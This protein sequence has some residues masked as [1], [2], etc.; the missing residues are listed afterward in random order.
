M[1]NFIFCAVLVFS[2]PWKKWFNGLPIFFIDSGVFF[3]ISCFLCFEA[4]RLNYLFIITELVI[5][6]CSAKKLFLKILQ[7]SQENTLP[8]VF[9]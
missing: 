4:E 5:Q 3:L 7:N 6:E 1:E 9:F 8:R 2:F